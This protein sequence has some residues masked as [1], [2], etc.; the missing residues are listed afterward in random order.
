MTAR[1]CVSGCGSTGLR[2]PLS[3]V[4]VVLLHPCIVLRCLVTCATV[5]M[6]AFLKCCAARVLV[7]VLGTGRPGPAGAAGPHG[8]AFCS[9]ALCAVRCAPL[10]QGKPGGRVG[11]ASI[12]TRRSVCQCSGCGSAACSRNRQHHG[13][14]VSETESESES[15]DD[16]QDDV[17]HSSRSSSA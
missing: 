3:Y 16:T 1:G 13:S 12:R 15:D 7:G 11:P 2:G 9:N 4:L 6:E 14:L 8:I 5:L 10:R 17:E